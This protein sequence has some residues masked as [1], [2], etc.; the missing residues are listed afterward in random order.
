MVGRKQCVLILFQHQINVAIQ[1]KSS[2]ILSGEFWCCEGVF[3]PS[4]SWL[5]HLYGKVRQNVFLFASYITSLRANIW[6]RKE[7]VLLVAV[8]LCWLFTSVLCCISLPTFL[9]SYFNLEDLK[10]PILKIWGI[11][12]ILC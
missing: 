10:C 3:R 4:A 9:I 12:N 6:E 11:Q 5:L 2:Y 8:F 7:N 1:G